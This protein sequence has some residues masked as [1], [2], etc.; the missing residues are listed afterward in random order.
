[1][2]NS[3]FISTFFIFVLFKR[4][5]WFINTKLSQLRDLSNVT[6]GCYGYLDHEMMV[7][8][9]DSKVPHHDKERLYGQCT[10]CTR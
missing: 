3:I 7:S 8:V 4:L 6:Q 5:T 2:K 10:D 9:A 1:M